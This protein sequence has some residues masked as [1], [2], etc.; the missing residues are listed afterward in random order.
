MTGNLTVNRRKISNVRVFV[1][2]R[3]E[4]ISGF[5]HTEQGELELA[6]MEVRFILRFVSMPNQTPLGRDWGNL[7]GIAGTVRD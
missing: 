2:L 6:A 5:W 4:C 3:R 1:R 7:H